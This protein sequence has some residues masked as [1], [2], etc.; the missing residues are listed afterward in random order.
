MAGIMLVGLAAFLWG[1]VGV[2][3]NLMI[4]R[5]AADPAMVGLARTALGAMSL[6]VAASALRLPL[7]PLSRLPTRSLAVFGLAGAAFQI[8]L[9]GAF[10]RVGVTVTVA[11]TVCA[12]VILMA[13]GD[14]LWHRR[15][16]DRGVALAIA[17]ASA[18]VLLALPESTATA[19]AIPA[20]DRLGVLLL[21]GA[22]VSFAVLAAAARNLTRHLHPLRAAGL[23][24]A[25]AA[26][27]LAIVVGVGRGSA[28]FSFGQLP[29]SDLAI[30]AYTGIAATG[31]AYFAFVIGMH[32][33]RSAAS[34]LAATLI[35]PGV[36]ALLAALILKEQL[37]RSEMTGCLLMLAAMVLLFA[38][39]RRRGS[40]RDADA[41]GI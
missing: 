10:Q 9:F 31:G 25:T 8:C 28:F 14:A 3:N 34:G 35:E 4:D 13:A 26:L 41:S 27:V 5:D 11:V 22:S 20:V 15:P 24:L 39:E 18:G 21:G 37:T 2:A 30:L 17:V 7:P 29:G 36:A 12:P 19:D 23:G 40:A 32:L 33:S 1:T 38:A 16:P 6:M